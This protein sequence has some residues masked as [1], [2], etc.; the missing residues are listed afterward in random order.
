MPQTLRPKMVLSPA[1][2]SSSMTLKPR[3]VS[4]F[5]GSSQI[6]HGLAERVRS[7]RQVEEIDPQ[8]KRTRK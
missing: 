6:L 2:L 1:M 7:V 3:H 8:I 4:D 5:S